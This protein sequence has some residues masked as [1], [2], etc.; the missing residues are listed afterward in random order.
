MKGTIIALIAS[1]A[2]VGGAQA[3]NFKK[4]ED[5]IH[6]RKS[7]FGVIAHNFGDMAAM[8]KGKKPYDQQVFEQRA[9][10]VAALAHI[11]AEGFLTKTVDSGTEALPKIWQEKAEFDQ[12]M[13]QFQKAAA[14]L[15]VVAKTGDK[16]AIKKAFG[17]TGKNCKSCHDSYKKD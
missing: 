10:N 11:P 12:I 16:K 8:L 17:A 15:A 6:Y 14:N 2:V 7:A 3:A 9:A 1:I 13:E 5:A 4:D